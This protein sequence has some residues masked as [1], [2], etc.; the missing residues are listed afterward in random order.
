MEYPDARSRATGLAV[1]E[2]ALAKKVVVILFKIGLRDDPEPFVMHDTESPIDI[3]DVKRDGISTRASVEQ[4][5]GIMD[6]D[7]GLQK[8]SADGHVRLRVIGKFNADDITFKESVIR[9]LQQFEA[10]FIMAE[11]QTGD[12]AVDRIDDRQGNDPQIV[13]FKTPHQIMQ[14]T[15]AILEQQTKLPQTRPV[16][17]AGG[18][19]IGWNLVSKI[20]RH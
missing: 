12:C 5:I 9:Q 8:R 11:N 17:T 7:L 15:N 3:V 20:H 10:T 2:A 18:L 13:P 19:G 6:V 1:P 4:R 16:P 14:G